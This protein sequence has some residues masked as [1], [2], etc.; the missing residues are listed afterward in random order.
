MV[1]AALNVAAEQVVEH[2]AYGALLERAG[3]RGPDGRAA[4]PLPRADIDE[5]GR[6]D[7]WVAIAVA[8]DDQWL[9]LRDALGRPE[10]AME[11]GAGR[12]AGRAGAPRRHRRAPLGVVPR[13][14]R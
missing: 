11:P 8:T 3:N 4:E 7:S 6:D 2:S 5:F 14:Q 13:P 10:W 1:D 12:H 9:A